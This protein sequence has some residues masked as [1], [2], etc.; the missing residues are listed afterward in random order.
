MGR[1]GAALVLLLAF[2]PTTRAAGP[3]EY[4]RDVKPVLERRCYACHGAL[5]QK[6]GLRLDDREAVLRGGDSG[7]ALAPGNPEESLLLAAIRH[8]D[9]D[10]EMPPRK[11]RF[12]EFRTCKDPTSGGSPTTTGG[13]ISGRPRRAGRPRER[14]SREGFTNARKEQ[15]PADDDG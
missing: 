14:P 11:D 8:S 12:S 7:P 9:P 10:L 1:R 2:T 3:V 4:L 13:E 15:P 5:E 6:G